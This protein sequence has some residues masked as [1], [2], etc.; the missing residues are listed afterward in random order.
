MEDTQLVAPKSLTEHKDHFLPSVHE[1]TE[2]KSNRVRTITAATPYGFIDEHLTPFGGLFSLEKLL[3]A[4]EI[5]QVF[6]KHFVAPKRTPQ[7]GHWT[8][9]K[10][11]MDLQFIGLQRLYHFIYVKEDAMLKG[12][13]DVAQ[14]PA[15]STFW[16][17]MNSYGSDQAESFLKINAVVRER[18]WRNLE[19]DTHYLHIHLD[20]D[21]TVK[22]VYGDK[23]EACKGHNPKHRGKKGLRPIITFIAETKEYMAGQLRKGKTLSGT[24]IKNHLFALRTLLPPSVRKVTLRADSEFYCC[25]AIATCRE[26]GFDY[27]IAVKKSRP[28]FNEN[29]WYSIGDNDD[30]QYNSTLYQPAKWKTPCR[31][32]AM[33]IR[34]DPNDPRN[35]QKEL[36]ED[37]LYKYRIFVTS[38]EAAPHRVID[39]YDD[40]AG[41][42][43]L[44]G[45][46]H[47]E[48]LQAVPSKSFAHNSAFFQ[49][50]MFS[51]NLWRYVKAFANQPE[52]T[53]WSLNTNEV[54][55]LKLLYLAAKINFHSD[56]TEIKYSQHMSVKPTWENLLMRLDDIRRHREI[57]KTL[58]TYTKN[59][60]R[61]RKQDRIV[62]KILCTE[63]G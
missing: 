37:D 20:A 14:L 48:G 13:L 15:V 63:Y 11:V 42:E 36:F 43:K 9:V 26:L 27:I 45:E 16:R 7:L 31:F 8:M 60:L 44:I 4:F 40:R 22:T 59:V 52:E 61:P 41:A 23:E 28:N 3:D 49:L 24:D 30:I 12:V 25:K 50:A 33:R 54:S 35:K 47:C 62:Q 38:R 2:A 56:R 5:E 21:T 17:C 32:V 18:V 53:A 10:G 39:E 46:A 6:F 29:N 1:H 55:R 57:W 34:K 19:Y 51:Y 58:P